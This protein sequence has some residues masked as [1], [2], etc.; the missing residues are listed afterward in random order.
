VK[1]LLIGGLLVSTI[2]PPAPVSAG[3]FPGDNGVIAFVRCCYGAGALD[4]YTF[5]ADGSSLTRLTETA[6]LAESG[7]DWSQDGKRI[8]FSNGRPNTGTKNIFVLDSS[9]GRISR[10][11]W[12][13]ELQFF[14]SWSPDGAEVVFEVVRGG[15]SELR[16]VDVVTKEVRDLF[17][18]KASDSYPQWGPT[19]D[20][21]FSRYAPRRDRSF[22]TVVDPTSGDTN[23]LS[24]GY[25]PSWSPD[26]AS[27]VFSRNGNLFV[28]SRD[29]A[30]VKRLTSGD[31]LD[32]SPAWSPDGEWIAF[33]DGSPEVWVIP[34]DGGVPTLLG[35]G[36]DP[37]WQPIEAT[38]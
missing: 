1:A 36:A 29:G 10:L 17:R 8:V 27:I 3:A 4:L 28:M 35:P 5:E 19:G 34:A 9:T 20:I 21:V 38:G 37:S 18:G 22:V 25:Y 13:S 16:I 30:D 26:G 23:R 14:P 24:A 33:T 11:T 6:S 15:R 2:A 31:R 32:L 12:G 7:P